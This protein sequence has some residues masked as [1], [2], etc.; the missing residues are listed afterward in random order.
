MRARGGG[1]KS[2]SGNGKEAGKG[3]GAEKP[4]HR[5]KP[6]KHWVKLM[7]NPLQ[8]ATLLRPK[9]FGGQDLLSLTASV[10]NTMAVRKALRAVVCP[11]YLSSHAS[12][13][14]LLT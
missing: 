8:G 9:H 3:G 14:F 12:V 10:K 2:E 5:Y 4:L 11:S 7:F 13:S 6:Y 1:S